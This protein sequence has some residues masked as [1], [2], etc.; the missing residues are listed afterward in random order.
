MAAEYR[1]YN[2]QARTEWAKARRKARWLSVLDNLDGDNAAGLLDFQVIA[3]RLNLKHAIYR[4]LHNIPLD[5]IVGSVGRY[6]DFSRA[7]LPSDD[8]I[9]DRWERIATLYLDP[10]SPGVPPIEVYKVGTSYFVKDGNHRV[11]VARQL[12]MEDIEAYVWEHPEPVTG[13]GTRGGADVDVDA[14]LL[15]V[16]RREF[17]ER[18][19]L[20]T[21]RPEADL[22]LT[23]PGGYPVLLHEIDAYQ[24]ALSQIDGQP[25]PYT[26]AVTNWYDFLYETTT[27]AIAESDVLRLFP[28]RTSADFYVWIKAYHHQLEVRYGRRVMLHDAAR[29]F[30]KHTRPSLPGRTIRTLLRWMVQFL[31]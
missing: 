9:R 8:S 21:L 15:E 5:Q 16:E 3:Q 24:Q 4:G 7:F 30:G 18:T 27:Q 29:D 25:V 6:Q 20:D 12:E 11:S 22:R 10:A 19:H 1:Y 28:E 23:A 2:D 14:L 26:E 17:L 13:L 31:L